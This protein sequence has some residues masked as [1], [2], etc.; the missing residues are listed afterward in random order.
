MGIWPQNC[1]C[2]GFWVKIHLGD[3]CH[4][5]NWALFTHPH[6]YPL[7]PSSPAFFPTHCHVC[8]FG[9]RC[10]DAVVTSSDGTIHRPHQSGRCCVIRYRCWTPS[11][12]SGLCDYL[13]S[14][15]GKLR[16]GPL[17]Q[18]NKYRAFPP[19]S[20]IQHPHTQK[21]PINTDNQ[22]TSILTSRMLTI[23]GKIAF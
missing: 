22:D 18:I 19:T 13:V 3:R 7:R 4:C 15:I 14:P 9:A 21:M 8:A 16:Y 2:C 12:L 23:S 6:L 11:P 1:I 5:P 10:V 17:K 20:K